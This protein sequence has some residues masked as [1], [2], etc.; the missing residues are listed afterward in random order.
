MSDDLLID[1]ADNTAQTKANGEPKLLLLEDGESAP[2][3]ELNDSSPLESSESSPRQDSEVSSEIDSQISSP[4]DEQETGELSAKDTPVSSPEST[5]RDDPEVASETPEA[6]EVASE[7]PAAPEVASETPAAP[8]IASETPAAPEVASETPATPEETPETTLTQEVAAESSSTPEVTSETP[9]NTEVTSEAPPTTEVTSETQS[10]PEV[11]PETPS[12]PETSPN[13]EPETVPE[14]QENG[15]VSMNGG[16]IKH[17]HEKE[18]EEKTELPAD[19]RLE[20]I[21]EKFGGK[22][23]MV[24]S[25]PY[26]DYL[27]SLGIGFF[28]RKIAGRAYHEMEVLIEKENKIVI[29]MRSFFHSQHYI[30]KL[31]EEME[32]LVE[33]YKHGV[34]CSY[35]NGKL[36]QQMTPLEIGSMAKQNQHVERHINEDGEQEVVF[37]AGEQTCKRYYVRLEDLNK[38]TTS[39]AEVEKDKTDEKSEDIEKTSEK[40]DEEKEETKDEKTKEVEQSNEPSKETDQSEQG[41]ENTSSA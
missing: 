16:D 17:D 18:T 6:P 37:T 20:E 10:S 2:T 33:K 30:F 13:K 11:Q 36:V 32:N 28:S 3:T 39:K 25:D 19:P 31:D 40:K 41:K 7:T 24:R 27:K 1:V 15:K 34:V 35:E 22:W 23:K 38:K 5:P 21:K 12:S 9:S 29:F 14:K 8:E 26:D 4:R